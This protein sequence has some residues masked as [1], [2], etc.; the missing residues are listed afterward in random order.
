MKQSEKVRLLIDWSNRCRTCKF[1]TGDRSKGYFA[2]C[3]CKE[4]LLFSNEDKYIVAPILPS[5]ETSCDKWETF[6]MEAEK[7]VIEWEKLQIINGRPIESP[8]IKLML[9][10]KES[11]K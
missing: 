1:W 3:I 6:D 2:A 11:K 4:S 7:I 5:R 10:N 8:D 9:E